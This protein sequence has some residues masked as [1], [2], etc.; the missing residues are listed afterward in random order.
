VPERGRERLRDSSDIRPERH[1]AGR[2]KPAG[3][4]LASIMDEPMISSNG[5]GTFLMDG[6]Q[7]QQPSLRRYLD[8]LK[9]RWFFIV[10]S[11]VICTG[12]A[13]VYAFTADKVYEA[14]TDML[15]TPVPDDQTA[16]LGLGLIRRASDPTRDVTTASRLI[17]NVEV[18]TVVA[19][20]LGTSESPESLLS[21]ISVE[22]VAQSSIVAVTASGGTPREAQL[23]ANSF[24]Q[25]AVKERTDQ[26]HHE[27]DGAIENMRKRIEELTAAN[28]NADTQ[29]LVEQLAT[30]ES[31]RSGPDPT[32][33]LETP[34][35]APTAPVSP[36][37]KLSLIGGAL[38]GLLLG[39][40]GAFALQALDTRSQRENRIKD[41]GLTVL[42]HVPDLR[43]SRGRHAFEEAFRFLRTAL[44]FASSDHPYG[45]VA[46]TSA[47]EREGKTTTSSQLAFA[48][49]E[50]GQTVILV[51]VDAYRPALR[52][53]IDSSGP[54]ADLDGPGLLDYLSD[55][56][57]L[58]EIIKTTNIP[59]LSFVP[60][61]S[62]ESESITGLLEQRQGAFVQEF[63]ELADLVILDC[64]P[65]GPRSDAILIAAIADAVVLV[66][67]AKNSRDKE[68][69][70]AVRLLRSAHAEVVGVVL[71][72]DDSI[73]A[74]YDYQ[75]ASPHGTR[76][77]A[78]RAPA[79]LWRGG[80]GAS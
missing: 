33:R 71:N 4:E 39:I 79:A 42:A 15:I 46:V 3:P 35:A 61:G 29:P 13:A 19:R 50:A 63:A 59:G 5:A 17:Q 22:P 80:R 41:M 73:S 72:R 16:V 18:A 45:T 6:E 66:V 38:A 23:L 37:V 51:E 32:L 76:R 26:L 47:A 65:V 24:A 56:A 7:A 74:E 27:L 77:E 67:D 54:G 25:G 10:L 12:V 60:A 53:V 1:T 70:G 43:R 21:H 9:A 49:L 14:H 36:R 64:P 44:R 20:D 31:L 62:L 75:R 11:V 34:A 48:A 58:D 40:A 69:E 57:S 28:G 78:S 2:A 30:L 55:R 8:T 68:V 52:R